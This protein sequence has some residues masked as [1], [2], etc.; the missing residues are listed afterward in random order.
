M[1]DFLAGLVAIVI[2]II[3]IAVLLAFPTMIL[4]NWVMPDI[5][6]LCQINFGQ[7]LGLTLLSSCLF[8]WGGI[9]GTK[10]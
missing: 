10:K 6:G 5:F 4:W 1:K 2:I 8:N 7:A 9:L 3:V